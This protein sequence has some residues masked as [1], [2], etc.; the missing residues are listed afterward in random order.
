[1]PVLYANR[2]MAGADSG[3]AG[4]GAGAAAGPA[5]GGVAGIA[6]RGIDARNAVSS[7]R[8]EPIRRSGC[9]GG[10]GA[11][12]LVGPAAAVDFKDSWDD[13]NTAQRI[14]VD[15]GAEELRRGFLPDGAVR[16]NCG[17]PFC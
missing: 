10:L 1:M 16:W 5:R 7:E 15:C 9:G 6:A 14:P 2:A 11:G 17:E 8:R 3:A 4:N 13:G 12:D